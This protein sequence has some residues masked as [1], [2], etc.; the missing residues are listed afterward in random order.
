MKRNNSI[1]D[2]GISNDIPAFLEVNYRLAITR[3][4]EIPPYLKEIVVKADQNNPILDIGCGV[5]GDISILK[6]KG[7]KRVFGV[8]IVSEALYFAKQKFGLNSIVQGNCESLP[9]RSEQFQCCLATNIIEHILYPPKLMEE[10]YRVLKPAGMV[11][12]NVPRASS[13]SDRILRWGG[14]VLHG[15]TSHIQKFSLKKARKLFME[16]NF[17]I[18]EEFESRGF[19]LDCPAFRNSSVLRSFY[20]FLERVLRNEL[21]GWRF[22]LQKQEK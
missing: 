2:Y 8:E 21:N 9:F 7:F 18:I 3:Q 15:K 4:H 19:D 13:M 14:V 12:I 1:S 17:S 16:N 22:V 10:I 6:S 11:V 5:G 20:R